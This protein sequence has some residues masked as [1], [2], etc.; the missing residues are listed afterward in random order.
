MSASAARGSTPPAWSAYRSQKPN[1]AACTVSVKC[2]GCRWRCAADSRSPR[3]AR[4]APSTVFPWSRA[5][6][7][8]VMRPAAARRPPWREKPRSGHVDRDSLHQQLARHEPVH[9]HELAGHVDRGNVP[10]DGHDRARHPV[11]RLAGRD[12][13]LRMRERRDGETVPALPAAV[14]VQ[15]AAEGGTAQP[16][17]MAQRAALHVLDDEGM[18]LA[19]SRGCMGVIRSGTA[20][21]APAGSAPSCSTAGTAG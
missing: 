15:Q 9:A 12:D 20:R 19:S 1:R 10:G 5:S 3:P 6:V 8:P 17:R 21:A 11:A 18:P 7:M 14:P 16:G 2:S 4:I 13:V